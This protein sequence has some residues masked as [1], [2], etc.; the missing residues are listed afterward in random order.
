MV[1]WIINHVFGDV[2]VMTSQLF[3]ALHRYELESIGALTSQLGRRPSSEDVFPELLK[4]INDDLNREAVNYETVQAVRFAIKVNPYAPI[5]PALLDA[6]GKVLTAWVEQTMPDVMKTVRACREKNLPIPIIF[7]CEKYLPTA[8]KLQAGFA[9][10][11]FS[12]PPVVVK[13][14]LSADVPNFA[15]QVLT[16]PVSDSYEGLPVKVFE[17]NVFFNAIGG[18]VGVIKIDDDLVPVP[19]FTLDLQT[20][21][22]SFA[23]ADYQ[24][25]PVSTLYHDRLWHFGKCQGPVPSVYG[26]PVKAAWARGALY[27]LSPAALEKL[28]QDYL[29][30]P[31]VLDGEL[32]EDKAVGNVLFDNGIKLSPRELEDVLG[33]NSGLQDRAP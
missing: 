10:R 16:L 11:Y 13:G 2:R 32:Y 28:V 9:E 12:I 33:L 31:G 15:D 29:R 6:H 14:D 5:I 7:S 3:S 22:T 1:L 25:R 19:D 27:Y 21:L 30:F 23:A 18:G 8:N 17:A 24:G 20:V 26:K 4:R